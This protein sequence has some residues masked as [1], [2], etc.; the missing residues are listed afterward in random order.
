MLKV[1]RF[2]CSQV[3]GTGLISA[4]ANKKKEFFLLPFLPMTSLTCVH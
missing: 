1:Y 3:F 4:T 2:E